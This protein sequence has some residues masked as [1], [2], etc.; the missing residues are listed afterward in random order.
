MPSQLLETSEWIVVVRNPVAL[1]QSG[2]TAFG[3][4]RL[5]AIE[6]YRNATQ[7]LSQLSESQFTLVVRFEDLQSDWE[8]V[9][10]RIFD[11]LSIPNALRDTS[12]LP[13]RGQTLGK[14]QT[15]SWSSQTQDGLKAAK[16]VRLGLVSRWMIDAGTADAA[17][18]W[19]YSSQS[20]AFS[21][22]LMNALVSLWKHAKKFKAL[23]KGG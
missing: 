19:G 20:S 2:M 1:I 12:R 5:G 21:R 16:K 22:T 3:W 18:R 4:S 9:A 7:D 15:S 13:V 8:K 17:E 11:H 23:V 6:N 10:A 14:G